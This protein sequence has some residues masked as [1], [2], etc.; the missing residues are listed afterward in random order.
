MRTNDEFRIPYLL[1]GIGLGALIGLLFALRPGEETGKSLGARNHN[2][3]DTLNQ[4]ATKLRE[5]DDGMV[6]RRK[7][8]VDP[9]GDSVDT[10]TE[11]KE[12]AYQEERR[13][14]LGG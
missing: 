9:R 2:D 7:E 4:Q 1:V 13:E 6:E 8:F 3:L 10:T 11:A 14:H 5:S 12:Q